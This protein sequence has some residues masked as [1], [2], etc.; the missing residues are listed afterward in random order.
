[1]TQAQTQAQGWPGP[2]A[3]KVTEHS[4]VPKYSMGSR[5]VEKRDPPRPKA[6]G[7]RFDSQIKSKPHLHPKKSD[8]PGP[9]AYV[10][11]SSIRKSMRHSES[12]QFS[13]FGHGSRGSLSQLPQNTPGPNAYSEV[14]PKPLEHRAYHND[15]Y[16]IPKAGEKGSSFLRNYSTPGPGNY[17]PKLPKSGTSKPILGGTVKKIDEP[18]KDSG[19][20]GPG[21]YNGLKS[22]SVPSFVICKPGL[23]S[24]TQQSNKEPV[25]PWK[26]TPQY[27]GDTFKGQKFPGQHEREEMNEYGKGS[28]GNAKRDGKGAVIE[29]ENTR[30]HR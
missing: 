28:F 23:R 22:H 13:T 15:G 16:S 11:P 17:D 12:T 29:D 1:M 9:G 18:E 27:P 8:E 2:S 20:P 10:T 6:N 5:F 4:G 3:Y 7:S 19:V 25:G 21:M 24:K 14:H 30:K 26:Y